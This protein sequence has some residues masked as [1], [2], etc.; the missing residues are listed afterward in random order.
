MLSILVYKKYDITKSCSYSSSNKYLWGTQCAPS[1]ALDHTLAPPATI[2][3]DYVDVNQTKTGV[4]QLTRQFK[5]F[6]N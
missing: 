1:T 6:K 2:K 5:I 3:T 4:V